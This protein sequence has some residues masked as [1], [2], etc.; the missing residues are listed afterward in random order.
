MEKQIMDILNAGL[1]ILRSGQEGL[2]KAKVDLE[3][4]YNDLVAKG[5][6]DNSDSAVKIRESVDKLLND[7]KELTSVAGKSYEETRAKI[8]E[9]YNKISEEIKNRM[10]EGQV[11]AVRQKIEE[12]AETIRKTTSGGKG[13]SS[14]PNS[15]PAS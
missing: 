2:D 12:V 15:N 7:V 14:A 8:I 4:A 6:S 1:G 9:N 10:P 11:E 5:S 3:K 13:S